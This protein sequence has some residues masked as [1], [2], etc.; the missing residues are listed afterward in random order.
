MS[1]SKPFSII[2]TI[3]HH[4]NTNGNPD[5]KPITFD[6][7]DT[8]LTTLHDNDLYPW[9]ILRRTADG[10]M[11]ELDDDHD[12]SCPP[13][14]N[15]VGNE[16]PII[17]ENGFVTLAVGESVQ[18]EAELVYSGTGVKLEEGGEYCI[19]FRGSWLRW[20]KLANL[21]VSIYQQDLVVQWESVLTTNA[22]VKT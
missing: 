9:L 17:G 16:V 21:E 18:V 14:D 2:S 1:L 4:A 12:T 11:E 3:T 5:N 22:G 8:C 13:F 20:W 7:K 6:L 19:N 15:E 10:E